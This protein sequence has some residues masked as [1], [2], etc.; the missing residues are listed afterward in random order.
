M[1]SIASIASREWL[2]TM[3]CDLCAFSFA[4]SAKH[5]CPNWHLLAPRH[6]RAETLTWRHSFSVCRGA[7]SRSPLPP[8]SAAD[9]AHVRSSSTFAPIEPSGI[10]MS[11]PWSSGAPSRIRCRQA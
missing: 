10:W 8:S 4:R 2:V 9:S 3:R 6:S 5:S 1:P 11:S 7:S